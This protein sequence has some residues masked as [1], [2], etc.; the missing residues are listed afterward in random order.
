M[1]ENG[2]HSV[3]TCI[4]ENGSH[5][6]RAFLLEM[7]L[8]SHAEHLF[9]NLES[10]SESIYFQRR[11]SFSERAFSKWGSL[12][13][14]EMR[15]IKRGSFSDRRS[16]SGGLFCRTSPSPIFRECPPPWASKSTQ[17]TFV[18]VFV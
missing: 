6:V 4:S 12:R 2:G 10:F 9:V 16:E 18:E 13:E 15:E 11:G 7:G 17:V 5:S 3:R 1:A 14:S 8:I